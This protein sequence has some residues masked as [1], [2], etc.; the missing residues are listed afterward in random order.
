MTSRDRPGL[1]KLLRDALQE[2]E[3][4]AL[5]GADAGG[6]IRTLVDGRFDL[7]AVAR[8]F[9]ASARATKLL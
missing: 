3:P 9:I 7:E 5:V 1:G 8:R 4:D 2:A 6:A